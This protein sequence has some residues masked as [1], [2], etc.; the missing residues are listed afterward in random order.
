MA[1][2]VH[3]ALLGLIAWSV[4]QVMNLDDAWG[5]R[6]IKL[7]K[8]VHGMAGLTKLILFGLYIAGLGT[9]ASCGKEYG[10]SG[11]ESVDFEC[12]GSMRC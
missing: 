5:R 10:S 11:S 1:F 8:P 9:M 4:V 2:I 6:Q 3:V 7:G 12:F